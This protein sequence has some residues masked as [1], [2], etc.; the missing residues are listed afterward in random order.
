MDL[1]GELNLQPVRTDPDV[2]VRRLVIYEHTTPGVKVIRDVGLT[3]GLNPRGT[4][5]SGQ[6]GTVEKR[7]VRIGRSGR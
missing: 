3:K 5:K 4:P 1:Y 6:L 7:P 2:W